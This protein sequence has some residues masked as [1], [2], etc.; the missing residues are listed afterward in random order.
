MVKNDIMVVTCASIIFR[1]RPSPQAVRRTALRAISLALLTSPAIATGDLANMNNDVGWP[2]ERKVAALNLGIVGSIITYGAVMWDWGKNP[3]FETRDEGWFGKNTR[4]GGADKLGH[5]YTGAVATAAATEIYRHWG[6]ESRRAATLGAYSGLL[7][8]TA[9]ELG[10]GFSPDHKFSWEDQV[11][12]MVG[13]GFEFLR[14]RH[15]QLAKKVQFRWEYFPSPAVRHGGHTDITTDYSGSRWLLA[16]PL[17]AWGARS[18]PLQWLEIQAGYG[19]RGYARRDQRYFDEAK[20]HPFIGI[21]IHIP[22]VLDRL[23]AGPGT[24]RV[25]EYIQIPGTALPLPP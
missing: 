24:Q 8:T 25:F 7:L 12:N 16:F 5:I 10:D 22:L 13:A 14:L 1:T 3:S 19:T 23:G 20:R 4:H 9:I 11:S 6:Y 17:R 15:P 21:G 18:S 2:R